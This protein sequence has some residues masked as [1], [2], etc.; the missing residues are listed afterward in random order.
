LE[1]EGDEVEVVEGRLED[2][3]EVVHNGHHSALLD[4]SV[5]K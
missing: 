1:E 5:A 3:E 4:L 2:A